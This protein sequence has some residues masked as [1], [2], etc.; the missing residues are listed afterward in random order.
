MKRQSITNNTKMNLLLSALFLGLFIASPLYPTPDIPWPW[1][2]GKKLPG[3]PPV[4]KPLV[5]TTVT[6]STSVSLIV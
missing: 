1:P 6:N 5:S 3:Q 2:T 4:G